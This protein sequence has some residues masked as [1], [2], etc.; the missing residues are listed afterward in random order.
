MWLGLTNR[1]SPPLGFV[2][3]IV[4][5]K[6]GGVVSRFKLMTQPP[7]MISTMKRLPVEWVVLDRSPFDGLS[8]CFKNARSAPWKKIM[9][10]VEDASDEPKIRSLITTARPVAEISI[11]LNAGTV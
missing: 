7:V 5:W 3:Q 10:F 11:R 8:L 9:L 6:L 1:Q 2:A 4:D